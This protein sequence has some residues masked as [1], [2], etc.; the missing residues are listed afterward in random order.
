VLVLVLV[1]V[2][3]IEKRY[4]IMIRLRARIPLVHKV[5][6]AHNPKS[7]Y[8]LALFITE[9]TALA[10]TLSLRNCDRTINIRNNDRFLSQFRS[11][12]VLIHRIPEHRIYLLPGDAIFRSDGE[13]VAPHS[14]WIPEVGVLCRIDLQL[15]PCLGG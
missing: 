5:S 3:V 14:R 15:A 6:P 12:K 8:N 1:L 13:Q 9:S 4:R 2:L 10:G 11:L 7:Q